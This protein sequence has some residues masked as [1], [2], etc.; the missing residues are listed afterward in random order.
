M[1]KVVYEN[2]PTGSM[3]GNTTD[4]NYK[5]TFLNMN[6]F[7]SDRVVSKYA[8]LEKNFWVLDGSFLNFPNNPVGLGYISSIISDSNGIFDDPVIITRTYNSNYTAPGL[9]IEFDS[10][11]DNYAI[12]MNVQWYRDDTLLSNQDYILQALYP[13][14]L[15]LTV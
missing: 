10:N 11:T 6:D 7:R 1:L 13:L 9:M 4:A 14:Y 15:E 2:I 5:Q 12:N 8:T 3:Q